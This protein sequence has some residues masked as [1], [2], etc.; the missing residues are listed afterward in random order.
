[1]L[2]S[3]RNEYSRLYDFATAKRLRI[4]NKGGKAVCIVCVCVRACVCVLLEGMAV[5]NSSLFQQQCI[6]KHLRLTRLQVLHLV[7]I[8][9]LGCNHGTEIET[10]S[11]FIF[12]L[13]LILFSGRV[14]QRTVMTLMMMTAIRILIWRR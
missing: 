1:M 6:T 3:T 14:S 10:L 13:L 11:E 5:G 9:L 12:W 8:L 7:G 2:T 4:R